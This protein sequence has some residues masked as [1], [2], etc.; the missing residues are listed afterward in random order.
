MIPFGFGRNV[1]QSVELSVS[2]S[3]ILSYTPDQS[4]FEPL[5]VFLELHES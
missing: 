1:T 4:L 3:V 2:S 5:I